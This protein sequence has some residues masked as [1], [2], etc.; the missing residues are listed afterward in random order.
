MATLP[1]CLAGTVTGIG[2]LPFTSASQ[3]IAAV[4]EHC[5]EV[6]F[7]PQLPRVSDDEGI[8]GQALGV[9]A[10]LLEPRS[11]GYGYDVKPGRIDAVI[12]ALHNSPGCLTS[13][14]AAG[15]AAFEEAMNAGVFGSALAVKGQI[16]GPVTLAAH[17]FYRDHAFLADRSLFA[18]VAFH[19]AQIGCW[20]IQRLKAFGLPVL[21]F[22]DEPALC[23]D[24]AVRSGISQDRRISALSAIFDDV[25]ARGAFA[26]LHCCAADPFARMGAARPDSLSFDAHQLLESFFA[27]RPVLDFV[28][29]GGWVAYGLIPTSADLSAVSPTSVFS[30]WLMAATMAGD[31]QAI[32]GRAMITSTCGL[33]LL[34]PE[35]VGESFRLARDTGK[36]FRRFAG[37]ECQDH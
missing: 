11:A 36:L 18:A 6:P 26:G 12:E 27:E 2:S 8:I 35:A 21:L 19:I 7:W 13:V 22:V 34:D 1:A 25:R 30:R 4:A 17:L 5:P 24:D 9:L 15:F 20:Q 31:A 3:G 10:G 23:L 14:N 29:S 32:A 33:G 16:E 37:V 28:E